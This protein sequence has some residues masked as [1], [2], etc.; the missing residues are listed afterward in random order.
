MAAYNATA[1][2]RAPIDPSLFVKGQSRAAG[3]R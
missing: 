2:E 1:Q 3:A